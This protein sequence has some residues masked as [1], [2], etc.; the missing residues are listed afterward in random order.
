MAT[1]A[2]V[3]S[4]G[5]CKGAFAVGVLKNLAAN[6]PELSFDIF[7]GTSTGSLIAPFASLGRVDILEKLY[8]SITTDQVITKGNLVER[9]LGSNSLFDATPLGNLIKQNY[10]DDICNQV[11]QSNKHVYLATTCLQTGGSVN[12]TN[13]NAKFDSDY[14]IMKLNN[15]DELRRAI[16]ASAC[17][18]VFMPPI[19]VK[20]GSLP[21]R[22]YVD[23]GVKEYA[24]V[25]LAID[26]GA[27]EIYTII[28]SPDTKD[29]NE[30]TFNDAFGI[31]EDT[32]DI[33]TS[34]VGYNDVR[35]PAMY[36]RALLYIASV[37]KKML[38][39]GIAQNKIDN[40]FNILSDNPYTG[41]KPLKIYIIRPTESLGGGMGGLDFDPTAMKGMLAKGQQQLDSFMASLNLQPAPVA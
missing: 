38:A 4:G 32:I 40:Y 26:A 22:H 13:S 8:T 15:P 37:Q 3:I 19:E 36:N 16:M 6:F 35:I 23:G 9:L 28:L 24:G 30:Q 27:D 7:I 39:D 12:F 11:L 29:V 34:G 14:D 18:P 5:G 33:F 21:M 31:L 10:V 25:Q 17:Q 1:R 20:K 41:K 2:L